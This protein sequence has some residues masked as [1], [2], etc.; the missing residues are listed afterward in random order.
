ME[1]PQRRL[2]AL[3]HVA[4][5]DDLGRM[6]AAEA[7]KDAQA[8]N[9]TTDITGGMMRDA[10]ENLNITEARMA[11]LGMP[12]FGPEFQVSCENHGGPGLVAV[13]QWDATAEEWNLISEFVQADMD[14]IQPL[15]DEDSA[16]Y[17]SEN[18]IE[19]SCK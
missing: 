1:G 17:A 11:S 12:N 5:T 19:S 10:M 14:V 7:A 6:L 15:I 2:Q 18:N 16:A 9:D 13:A 3:D 4:A 8:A